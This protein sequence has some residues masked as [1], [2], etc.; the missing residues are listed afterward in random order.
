MWDYEDYINLLMYILYK[1]LWK[2]NGWCCLDVS[3]TDFLSAG[4]TLCK[5]TR[6]FVKSDFFLY[7]VKKLTTLTVKN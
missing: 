6:M 3:V 4:A 5:Y 1:D 7:V 2:G